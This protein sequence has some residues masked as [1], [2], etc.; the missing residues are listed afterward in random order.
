[1]ANSYSSLCDDF[2][3]DLHVNTELDLPTERDTIL[4]FFERIEKQ[5]PGMGNFQRRDNG[6]FSLEEDRD[7]Q[8][9]RWITLEMDR[10]CA[11][12]ANPAL[13]EDAYSLQRTVLEL[14]P[15][16]LGVNHLDI[17]SLDVTF[18]MDFD[19]QG[20]H[21]EVIADAL[22][23]NSAFS[24][25]LEIPKARPL[26]FSPSAIVSLSQ[27]CYCQARIAIESRTTVYE[28]RNGKYKPD[29]PI[30]LYFTVRRYPRPGEKFDAP[31]SFDMQCR[32]AE[33]MMAEKIFPNF[34]APLINAIAQRR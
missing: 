22:Y 21:D 31:R 29:E 10:L 8:R 14:S 11:G 20:N 24:S 17:D 25:L 1:M 12:C 30:S 4:H 34:A 26:G 28:V 6:D 23:G 2:F 18:T 16:M 9:Y 27:D 32:I 3:V 33:D 13:M 5:F 7:G 19:Y 15:Y